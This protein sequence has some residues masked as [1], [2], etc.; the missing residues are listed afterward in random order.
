MGGMVQG[1]DGYESES[2]FRALMYR[3]TLLACDGNKNQAAA[4][5]GIARTTLFRTLRADNARL[6][7]EAGQRPEMEADKRMDTLEAARL[8]VFR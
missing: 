1:S 7:I 5:L 4:R 8:R 3:R 6:E 2:R